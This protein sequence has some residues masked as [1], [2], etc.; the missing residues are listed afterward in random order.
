[1]KKTGHS[2]Y[3]SSP[4]QELIARLLRRALRSEELSQRDRTT[5]K[6]IINKL[7]VLERECPRCGSVLVANRTRTYCVVCGWEEWN[8]V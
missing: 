5:A 1:M 2:I 7:K 3:L 6:N 4:E 8:S